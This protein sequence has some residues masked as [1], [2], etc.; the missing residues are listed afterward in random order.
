MKNEN[1]LRAVLEIGTETTCLALG[2]IEEG[3]KVR[4]VALAR[5]PSAGSV[6]KS[7]ITDIANVSHAIRAAVKEIDDK[8]AWQVGTA[9]LVVSGA[10]V[11]E[12][13][14]T[15]S[16]DIEGGSVSE[17]KMEEVSAEAE[18]AAE[19][20]Q[21]R[22]CLHIEERSWR[23]DDLRGV[24]NP[25][26]MSGEK[27][28]LDVLAVD[29]DRDRINDARKAADAAKLS[30]DELLP[31]GIAAAYAVASP[32][33]ASAGTLFIDIGAGTTNW[34][35]LK[36]DGVAAFASLGVG[37]AYVTQD[38]ARAFSCTK[39]AAGKLKLEAS[40]TLLSERRDGRLELPYSLAGHE[41][42][43]IS[44]LS[45]DLVVNARLRELLAIIRSDLEEKNL[46]HL[47][48]GGVVL[49]GGGAAQ[50]NMRSLAAQVFGCEARIGEISPKVDF[51]ACADSIPPSAATLATI[52][53]AFI[54]LA[55]NSGAD[56]ETGA[57]DTIW[58]R[59]CGLFKRGV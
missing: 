15:A 14:F 42:K 27:L 57:P 37:S 9:S 12:N 43:T 58:G 34:T 40:A 23:V 19:N 24:R 54:L 21:D 17:E 11:R 5:V 16:D 56:D 44:R 48:R 41:T 22:E 28:F 51:S 2:E 29:A 18:R 30:I 59:F 31:A 25:A 32:A 1:D 13:A 35:L 38:I 3:G 50:L 53:G 49:T 10:H 8:T 46:F 47:L 33:D 4:V 6:A 55:Q 52:A 26:G 36:D 39:N 20:F 45:L 7:R